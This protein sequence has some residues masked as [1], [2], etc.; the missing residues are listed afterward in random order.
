MFAIFWFSF[1]LIASV[2]AFFICLILWEPLIM[3]ALSFS[4]IT[5]LIFVNM[6]KTIN[7]NEDEIAK[8]KKHLGIKDGDPVNNASFYDSNNTPPPESYPQ[9]TDD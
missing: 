7:A 5:C 2:I 3:L 6:S 9:E 4:I 8:L 1:S